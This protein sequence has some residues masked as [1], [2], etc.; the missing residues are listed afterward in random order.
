MINCWSILA[1]KIFFIAKTKSDLK[2]IKTHLFSLINRIGIILIIYTCLLSELR[3]ETFQTVY[4][5]PGADKKSNQTLS[6][7]FIAEYLQQRK[8]KPNQKYLFFNDVLT[9]SNHSEKEY[10]NMKNQD[11]YLHGIDIVIKVAIY[12]ERDF[13]ACLII[14]TST[15]S[16]TDLRQEIKEIPTQEWVND[17]IDS[18]LSPKVLD[19]FLSEKR[20]PFFVDSNQKMIIL[21]IE[22]QYKGT[23]VEKLDPE[24]AFQLELQDLKTVIKPRKPN[25]GLLVNLDFDKSI[26]K[27]Y[28]QKQMPD[29]N[30]FIMPT[31][32][33]ID[34]ILKINY[35]CKK[36]ENTEFIEINLSYSLS[37]GCTIPDQN[38][39]E[40]TNTKTIFS[41]AVVEKNNENIILI[42]AIERIEHELQ[43]NIR[44]S[45]SPL[46]LGGSLFSEP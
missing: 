37:Y 5:R 2:G 41:P 30:F 42:R 32:T 33:K 6:S 1:T 40:K 35:S 36:I 17:T 27:E 13:K 8:L 21:E 4:L 24:Q 43:T 22:E 23:P 15:K 29:Y 25:I 20:R 18:F 26:L 34:V 44:Q 28:L 10:I 9:N 3:A 7:K 16:G 14:C 31:D 39:L 19:S 45:L 12:D 11:L 38:N 46:L